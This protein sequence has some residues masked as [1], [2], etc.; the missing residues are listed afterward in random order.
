MRVIG[1]DM[2]ITERKAFTSELESAR[3]RANAGARV[4]ALEQLRI[5]Q[6]RYSTFFENAPYDMFVID[7]RADGFV[8]EQ[9][10]PHAAAS[11]G[12]APDAFVGQTP[13]Q[14]YPPQTAAF[15]AE[16][17]RTCAATG[18]KR[19][20]DVS[21]AASGGPTMRHGILVPLRYRDG[22]V[23]K[24]FCTSIDL[25][26]LRRVEDALRQAQKMEAIG[27]LTGG[28]AHDFN[29]LL[30]VITGNLTL[31]EARV[32]GAAAKRLIAA[33]QRGAD[34]GARLTQ[35]LLAFARKQALRPERVDINLLIKEFVPVLKGATGDAI[36]L[37]LLLSPTL[38]PC[39][40]D[41]A[42][43]QAAI[44]NLVRNAGDAIV[45]GGRISIETRI[46]TRCPSTATRGKVATGP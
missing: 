31:L 10:N 43:F 42:Q 28:V 13:E 17:Y 4:R 37:Q 20:F 18:Q 40:V 14:I 23:E 6:A 30:T 35:S 27:H 11:M 9:V 1:A 45:G 38:H 12:I 5:S 22:K 24:L 16:E 32:T 2:D 7:V 19:E 15:L 44:L 46:S 25:T 33:A 3:R 41:P 21:Y 39:R 26:E 34:R 29:N 8:F 36:E